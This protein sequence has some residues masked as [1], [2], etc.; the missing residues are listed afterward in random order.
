MKEIILA[1]GSGTRHSKTA[2]PYR[3]LPGRDG[4][5]KGFIGANELRC[6]IGC[7]GNSAYGRYL[8][9]FVNE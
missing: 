4:F 3:R 6:L 1:G 5:T 2:R 7:L 9:R 8:G